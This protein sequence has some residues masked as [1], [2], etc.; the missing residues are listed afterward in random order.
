VSG[1]SAFESRPELRLADHST[2]RNDSRIE[3]PIAHRDVTTIMGLLGDIQS[4]VRKIRRLLEEEDEQ[5]EE[6][7]EDDT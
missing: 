2:K 4:D 6:T 7:P 5:E 3:L 1:P